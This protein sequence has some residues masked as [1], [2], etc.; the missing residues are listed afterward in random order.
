MKML[1]TN[2]KE[3]AEQ[4]EK[5]HATA[6]TK[7]K[8]TMPD[9]VIFSALD[10]AGPIE[11]ELSERLA[12]RGGQA[13]MRRVFGEFKFCRIK[14]NARL[15]AEN[16]QELAKTYLH[17]L[18]HVLAN[19]STGKNEGHGRKWAQMM[20]ILGLPAERCHSMDVSNFKREVKR[21]T[22]ACDAC[23]KQY[24]LTPYKHNAQMDRNRYSC[25]V[26]RGKLTFI[27]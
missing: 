6:I 15:H 9:S 27:A 23:N 19:L 7:L 26:C 18:A 4:I 11:V 21:F 14:I 13:T 2:R 20:E 16:P 17:E 5:I 24:K 12:T 10:R 22:W 1:P 3:M 25:G 8:N